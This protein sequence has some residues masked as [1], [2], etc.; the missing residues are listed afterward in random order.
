MR[1]PARS[2][3]AVELR[4]SRPRA[5]PRARESSHQISAW[6][7]I[8]CSGD[9]GAAI[10]D[11]ASCAAARGHAAACELHRRARRQRARMP[12]GACRRQTAEAGDAAARRRASPASRREPLTGT[13]R[14]T[15]SATAHAARGTARA[16]SRRAIQLRSDA[17]R[18]PQTPGGQE[19]SSSGR[20]GRSRSSAIPSAAVSSPRASAPPHAR[21]VASNAAARRGSPRRARVPAR[22]STPAAQGSAPGGLAS[23]WRAAAALCVHQ[24][25]G[26]RVHE[27]APARRQRGVRRSRD[28]ARGEAMGPPRRARSTRQPVAQPRPRGAHPIRRAR[29]HRAA[30]R[31]APSSA[32][33]SASRRASVVCSL[34]RRGDEAIEPPRCRS[35]RDQSRASARYLGRRK[36]LPPDRRTARPH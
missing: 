14:P 18:A 4:H 6:Q 15:S 5:P 29:R 9:S 19:M 23:R 35:R 16:A 11:R 27:R 28:H 2:R 17:R 12:S 13:R 31:Q 7:A 36:A 10:T 33:A 8:V 21:R 25:R 32:T 3:R 34:M 26:A 22:R 24:P 30:R 1:A 20:I